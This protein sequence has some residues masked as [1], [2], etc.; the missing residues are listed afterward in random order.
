MFSARGISTTHQQ[1]RICVLDN[2][3]GHI[4]EW[5]FK[6]EAPNWVI[7]KRLDQESGESETARVALST[8]VS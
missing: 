6:L 3:I 8:L 2:A 4:T 1:N 5:N 7:T